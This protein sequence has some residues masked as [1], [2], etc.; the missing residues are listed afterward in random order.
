MHLDE[1]LSS[2][3]LELKIT[4]KWID[5][6][7]S[8]IDLKKNYLSN[9]LSS[10]EVEKIWVP[11]LMLVNTRDRSETNFRSQTAQIFVQINE[12]V[13]PKQESLGNVHNTYKFKGKDW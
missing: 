9:K 1:V 2:L 6:R 3:S 8:Y 10:N 13:T 5:P 7:V 4:A 11:T 12:G